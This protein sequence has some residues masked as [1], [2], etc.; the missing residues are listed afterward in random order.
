MINSGNREKIIIIDSNS[1]IHRA[2]HALPRLTTKKGEVVNAV[3]GFLL[4]FLKAIKSFQ[5]DYIAATFDMP[6]LTFRHKKYKEYKAK[7][8][9]V[10]EELY[11]QFPLVKEVLKA[12]NVQIFEKDGFEADDI[13]GTIAS[14]V[15]DGE[16]P[17]GVSTIILSGDLDTLQL[18]NPDT[19]VYVLRR[20]VKDVVLYDE[21]MAEERF[22]G[23]TPKQLIDYKALRGD[24]SDNI[25]GVGGIGDKTAIDLLL[26]FGTLENIYREIGKKTENS[27]NIKAKLQEALVAEKEQAF[28]SKN[29][30]EIE[31]NVPI[32]FDLE[33]CKWGEYDQENVVEVLKKMEF[34]SLVKRLPEL[35][36]GARDKDNLEKS[37]FQGNLKLW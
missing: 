16:K 23:L 37:A 5:P 36:E 15:K 27:K 11:K 18:I 29:L 24:P 33:K 30:V 9:P 20:G 14:R 19:K 21:K 1:V 7:R 12:F 10:A 35:R 8:P 25:P 6:G 22:G 28:L 13:I 2:Y 17:I 31:K 34:H 4:V 26:G 3:Y 32:D